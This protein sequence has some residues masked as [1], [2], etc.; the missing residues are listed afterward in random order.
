MRASTTL[1]KQREAL[2]R[3]RREVE[4][5]DRVATGDTTNSSQEF[6][7]QPWSD[8]ASFRARFRA[9]E[10]NSF[11][12]SSSDAKKSG[13]VPGASSALSISGESIES[14]QPRARITIMEDE[15]TTGPLPRNGV[16]DDVSLSAVTIGASC[17]PVSSIRQ[18]PS[19]YFAS[20]CTLEPSP[21]SFRVCGI[22]GRSILGNSTKSPV[23]N[24]RRLFSPRR[25][26][27]A[28][29]SAIGGRWW[30][31]HSGSDE[32]LAETTQE[33]TEN[34]PASGSACQ[35]HRAFQVYSDVEIGEDWLPNPEISKHETPETT[36]VSPDILHD[37]TKIQRH[38]QG[39]FLGTTAPPEARGPV[40]P[41]RATKTLIHDLVQR[42]CQ[43]STE[44]QESET[45]L[46]H[47][48]AQR[49][50]AKT[51]WNKSLYRASAF[52]GREER[53]LQLAR[54]ELEEHNLIK[55]H[56]F[57]AFRTERER[58]KQRLRGV[59]MRARQA[60]KRTSSANGTRF[61]AELIE[62]S[63]IATQKPMR[64]NSP[65]SASS[66]SGRARTPRGAMAKPA[67]HN[68]GLGPRL[69]EAKLELESSR[70][71][72]AELDRRRQDLLS[73]QGELHDCEQVLRKAAKLS[74][75]EVS[76]LKRL[77][78]LRAQEVSVSSEVGSLRAE[79]DEVCL[80]LDDE[81]RGAEHLR[82]AQE[83]MASELKVYDSRFHQRRADRSEA[84][85]TIDR[86]L[87][88]SSVGSG[89]P[90]RQADLA[91]WIEAE[92]AVKQVEHMKLRLAEIVDV[93]S[94]QA[95]TLEL[96]I[97][98]LHLD[99]DK[100]AAIILE[101]AGR[102]QSGDVS[103]GDG[104]PAVNGIAGGVKGGIR[105]II[106][107]VD[108]LEMQALAAE[109]K[110]Q[111]AVFDVR[112]EQVNVHEKSLQALLAREAAR[113]HALRTWI[114]VHEPLAD[115]RL[116]RCLDFATNEKALHEDV[117]LMRGDKILE[118]ERIETEWKQE[119]QDLLASNTQAKRG[120]EDFVAE[121][122][123]L[124]KRYDSLQKSYERLLRVE[125]SIVART[126]SARD[127][128]RRDQQAL[129]DAAARKLR[130]VSGHPKTRGHPE[131]R[132]VQ[133]E[134]AR[135]A[136]ETSRAEH[137]K[138]LNALQDQ[139]VTLAAELHR[140]GDLYRC[141]AAEE[142]RKTTS[143]KLETSEEELQSREAKES[144]CAASVSARSSC[145]ER[146]KSLTADNRNNLNRRLQSPSRHGSAVC[147][148]GQASKEIDAEISRVTDQLRGLEARNEEA[149]INHQ[150]ATVHL[151]KN[152][153]E[154][155]KSL[156]CRKD[157]HRSASSG[158]LRRY[159]SA[160]CV[161]WE[162]EQ[163]C[164]DL[165]SKHAAI[166]Q[167]LTAQRRGI[168]S[169][170]TRPNS[171]H[172]RQNDRR[173]SDPPEMESSLISPQMGLSLSQEDQTPGRS[174]NATPGMENSAVSSSIVSP[175]FGTVSGAV[176][177][178]S[179]CHPSRNFKYPT[180]EEVRERTDGNMQ[181]YTFYLQIYPLLRGVAVESWKRPKRRFESRQ[182]A[183][184]NDLQ[185]LEI[186]QVCREDSRLNRSGSSHAS[187]PRRAHHSGTR[188][189][190]TET[191]VRMDVVDRL[192]I[193]RSTQA[194]VRHTLIADNLT[195]NVL[196]AGSEA[197]ADA[198][199]LL[200]PTSGNPESLPASLPFD[201]VLIGKE[202]WRLAAT[203]AHTFQLVTTA[204]N[205]L[206]AQR[207]SLS[208]FAL[209]LG[210]GCPC[211]PGP[212]QT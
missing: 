84:L 193:P 18:S 86:Y 152:I 100:R 159:R 44:L 204:L 164:A 135:E 125:R 15:S 117:L 175:R 87:S 79:V 121:A 112:S 170:A 189:R 61:Q 120:L 211:P 145:R 109:L 58:L 114:T 25:R 34:D 36:S 207:T 148:I 137:L 107:D 140:V 37:S 104:G 19:S 129:V 77:S 28:A 197:Q 138:S 101:L 13:S 210:L 67:V 80:E 172:M 24:L 35:L 123:V 200:E 74:E 47:A 48:E 196:D 157:E 96:S 32:L 132:Q 11:A 65:T 119:R 174:R 39:E 73:E 102:Q 179:A 177:N 192:Y 17:S 160:E 139:A 191:F 95:R 190:I 94:S 52:E 146:S 194:I 198:G 128:V 91:E 202:S 12:V 149:E 90:E 3:L 142:N 7:G 130:A 97:S 212:T 153:V 75:R 161:F 40:A 71:Q 167:E 141:A 89:N 31:A 46:A 70:E 83:R 199:P 134:E 209:I 105:Q 9:D 143:L 158:V 53:R 78:D 182:L 205:V 23:A 187:T 113:V 103:T 147:L 43:I 115:E 14:P 21:T 22:G 92:I 184:S 26:N 151:E 45:E 69:R 110:E 156:A 116:Q 72:V 63:S 50:E 5:L 51:E 136:V 185:R 126:V 118:F 16:E 6:A 76:N 29:A 201:V 165:R 183:I 64:N 186:C 176:A 93:A 88:L 127:L 30:N 181:L 33:K 99:L 144:E 122:V 203:D 85:G 180:L 111:R 188:R 81:Q 169:A 42:S 62:Q 171:A 27:N 38:V 8:S 195:S 131:T 4:E 98:D 60:E 178:S 133:M 162:L 49:E 2:D 10:K 82:L 56:E 166:E 208:A 154:F 1:Q 163:A 150:T 41:S 168:T 155:Q 206:I 106:N 55:T 59:R 124:Q 173:L 68:T 20:P 57:G 54:R 108:V 66:F